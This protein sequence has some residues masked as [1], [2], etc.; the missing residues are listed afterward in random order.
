MSKKDKNDDLV[1]VRGHAVKDRM[2]SL[3]WYYPRW[4]WRK[5]NPYWIYQTEALFELITKQ[6]KKVAELKQKHEYT[7]GYLPEEIWEA[8]QEEQ[9]IRQELN[10]RVCRYENKDIYLDIYDKTYYVFISGEKYQITDKYKGE[11]FK[12]EKREKNE[13]ES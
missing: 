4:R 7:D 9:L 10:T 13:I 11:K 12:V 8:I 5:A 3:K 6:E 1:E 2:N